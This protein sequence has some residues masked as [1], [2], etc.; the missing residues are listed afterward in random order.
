MSLRPEA[1]SSPAMDRRS[2]VVCFGV[3]RGGEILC[4]PET[5]LQRGRCWPVVGRPGEVA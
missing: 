5:S 2:G 3:G 1:A 4:H